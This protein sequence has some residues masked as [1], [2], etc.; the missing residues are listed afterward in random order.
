MELS[1]HLLWLLSCITSRFVPFR[2]GWTASQDILSPT[3]SRPE[4]TVILAAGIIGLSTAYYLSAAM[5]ETISPSSS[6]L[7]PAIVVIEPSHDIC[8]GASG[9]ATG[10][11]GD[12]GFSTETS[13]LG[14]L[15]Y[16]LHKELASKY[17][18][19]E[20]YGFRDLSV[21]RVSPKSFTGSPSPPDSWGPSPPVEKNISNLPN[22]INPS[23]DWAVHSLADAPHAAHLYVCSPCEVLG[24]IVNNW[25][26]T[27]SDSV[28]SY[29]NAAKSWG[30]NSSSTRRP[31][32][33]R[34]MVPAR[35]SRVS[36]WRRNR[37]SLLRRQSLAMQ[38]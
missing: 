23:E 1:H 17:G 14:S 18:G 36:P 12:V 13:P 38:W 34:G 37:R 30:Y 31:P 10:G 32:P 24:V 15:S 7:Q 16:S 3:E 29:A 25:L 6:G 19:R 9:E 27:R 5:N 20:K 8:P 28:N 33:S 4:S 35:A 11:L 22:W 21:F 2:P 26:G